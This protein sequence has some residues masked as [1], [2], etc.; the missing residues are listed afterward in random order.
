MLQSSDDAVIMAGHDDAK[1][2]ED[3][4]PKTQRTNKHSFKND[5]NQFQSQSKELVWFTILNNGPSTFSNTHTHKH[6]YAHFNFSAFQ[7]YFNQ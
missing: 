3:F 6:T 2:I 5:W 1:P 7:T 4:S